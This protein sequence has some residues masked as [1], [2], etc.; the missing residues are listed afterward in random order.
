MSCREIARDATKAYGCRVVSANVAT[1]RHCCRG[2]SLRTGRT[3]K[4][5]IVG[6][7]PIIERDPGATHAE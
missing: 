1:E 6:M 7:T 4:A 3:A 2:S 5:P